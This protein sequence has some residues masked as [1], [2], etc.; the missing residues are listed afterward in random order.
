LSRI[1]ICYAFHGSGHHAAALA[2]QAALQKADPACSCELVNFFRCLYPSAGGA[3]EAFYL[4][5]LKAVPFLW[6]FFYD[7]RLSGSM[8]AGWKTAAAL[9]RRRVHEQMARLQPDAVICTQASPFLFLSQS[10]KPSLP[11]VTGVVTDFVPH[12]LWAGRGRGVIVVPT[13]EAA[14]RLKKLGV[15]AERLRVLGIP[16]N[17]GCPR[18]RRAPSH[19]GNRIVLVMG[20]GF[21]LHLSDDIIRQ[22]DASPEAFSLHVIAGNNDVFRNSLERQRATFRHPLTVLGF[23]DDVPDRL[24]SADV[25]VTKPGGMTS[26][27]ALA[28]GVPMILLPPLP[29]QEMYNRDYLI[30]AGAAMAASRGGAGHAVTRLL[31]DAALAS[32]VRKRMAALAKP[33]AAQDIARFVLE[34]LPDQ[35]KRFAPA[36]APG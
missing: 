23:V 13:E 20:G 8:A 2:L 12:R 17:L 16:V 10:R 18:P 5:V 21:G 24:S 29:G 27:E 11:P 30:G 22:I 31:S 14:S 19:A 6:Q 25:L 9:R 32:G 15:R 26:A 28:H 33:R 4:G 1:V 34:R 7:G 3:I 35:P 36:A